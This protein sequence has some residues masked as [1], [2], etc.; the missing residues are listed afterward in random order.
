MTL[1]DLTIKNPVLAWML[2]IGIVVFGLIS[3]AGL[4]I[5]NLPD[6]D[7]PVLTIST[8]WPGAAPDVIET[9]VTD[10]IE[11]AV[12]GVEGVIEMTS[13]SVRGNS[14]VTVYF[15]LSKNVDIAMLEVQSKLS[16][17][18]RFLPKDIYTP[19]ISKSNPDSIPIV[20]L[21]VTGDM[22]RNFIME[23]TNDHIVDKF[24]TIAGVSTVFLGGYLAPTFRIWLDPDKMQK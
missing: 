18:Q 20:W 16:Q 14:N 17:A 23:Y 19:V 12:L 11:A 8:D 1:S 7:F 13:T 22:D 5:S 9:S 2:L 15:D 21:A 3:Y 24:T 6:V 10:P 4:G